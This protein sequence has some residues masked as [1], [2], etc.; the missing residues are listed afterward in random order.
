MRGQLLFG[1][2][3]DGIGYSGGHPY[4]RFGEDLYRIS[5]L[6]E[7]IGSIYKNHIYKRRKNREKKFTTY[8]SSV[9]TTPKKLPQNSI[10]VQRNKKDKCCCE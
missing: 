5:S 10:Y 4:L 3:S 7:I 6:G 9:F 1:I 2:W 8:L